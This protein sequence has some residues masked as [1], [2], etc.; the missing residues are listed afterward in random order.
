MANTTIVTL[1]VARHIK[2]PR[3]ETKLVYNLLPWQ[4]H[5]ALF[6]TGEVMANT[7]IVT[8]GVARHTKA[9]RK[10]THCY[11]ILHRFL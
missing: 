10:E 8:L 6:H 1:G 11:S 3:K 2:A 4:L 9:P 5:S 7:T